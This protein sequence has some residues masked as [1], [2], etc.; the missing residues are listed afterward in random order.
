LHYYTH[1]TY[2]NGTIRLSTHMNGTRGNWVHAVIYVRR[3]VRVIQ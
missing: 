3:F 1:H 2:E